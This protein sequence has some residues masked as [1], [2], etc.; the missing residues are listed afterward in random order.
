MCSVTS[1]SG[2]RTPEPSRSS[3]PGTTRGARP[4]G[5]RSRSAAGHALPAWSPTGRASRRGGRG[6]HP[7]RLPPTPCQ[8]RVHP[9]RLVYGVT[10]IE[11]WSTGCAEIDER[12][13]GH[14]IATRQQHSGN[15][16]PQDS[17]LVRVRRR[18]RGVL[19]VS[20]SPFSGH[21]ADALSVQVPRRSGRARQKG[22]L[23][24]GPAWG[25]R[26]GEGCW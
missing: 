3:S 16:G 24:G 19:L 26:E 17:R 23:T 14:L 9:L 22:Q 10:D 1:V 4:P 12:L 15:V 8:K 2:E 25:W 20:S 6:A 18:K 13:S 5:S 11:I 21:C 7:H